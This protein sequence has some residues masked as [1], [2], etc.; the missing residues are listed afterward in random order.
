MLDPRAQ[1][2]FEG[3]YIARLVVQHDIIIRQI[4]RGDDA[5]PLFQLGGPEILAK[6]FATAGLGDVEESRLP[7]VLKYDSAESAV[8]AAFAGGPV[9]LA[10]SRFDDATREEAHAEYLASI[11]KH[12]AGDG[13]DIPGEFVIVGGTKP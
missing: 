9:A 11:E 5:V 6:M 7:V 12:K 1:I 8:G 2:E 10:Y 4:I 13:Y 3:P